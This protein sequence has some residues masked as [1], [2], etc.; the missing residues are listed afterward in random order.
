MPVTNALMMYSLLSGCFQ[1]L[2]YFSN[3]YFDLHTDSPSVFHT[4]FH[5]VCPICPMQW[6]RNFSAKPPCGTDRPPLVPCHARWVGPKGGPQQSPGRGMG[7][8]GLGAEAELQ[9]LLRKERPVPVRG[10]SGAGSILIE[11]GKV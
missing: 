2:V 11:G 7:G 3:H 9:A 6:K 5:T 4:M 1:A 10:P 8:G